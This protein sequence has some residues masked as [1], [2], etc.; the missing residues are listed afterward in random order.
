MHALSLVSLELYAR[1]DR[2]VHDEQH[3][4]VRVSEWIT[5][6]SSLQRTIAD[7]DRDPHTGGRLATLRDEAGAVQEQIDALESQLLELRSRQR[8]VQLELSAVTNTVEAQM[9]S[10]TAALALLDLEADRYITSTRLSTS[11]G[12]PLAKSVMGGNALEALQERTHKEEKRARRARDAYEEAVNA[13]KEGAPVWARVVKT[14]SEYE[15]VLGREIVRA[16]DEDSAQ[17]FPALLRE[18]EDVIGLVETELVVAEAKGWTLLVCAIGAELE[19]LT[20]GCEVLVGLS[21][22]SASVEKSNCHVAV[23]EVVRA[24]E[25]SLMVGEDDEPGPDFL[26]SHVDTDHDD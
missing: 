16:N 14:V 23:D 24:P 7:T 5:R 8:A 2:R 3:A 26:V 13:L 22:T 19:A 11:A 25:T 1:A 6:R 15:R 21:A 12:D 9:S 18:L 20:R 17:R 10:Y 4:S